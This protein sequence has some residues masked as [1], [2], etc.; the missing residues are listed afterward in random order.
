MKIDTQLP[1]SEKDIEKYFNETPWW[2]WAGGILAFFIGASLNEWVGIIAG[3]GVTV[4]LYIHAAGPLKD[5]QIDEFWHTIAKSRE[6]EA[7][8]VANY[9]KEDVIRDATY[10]FGYA[11][12]VAPGKTHRTKEGDD[13][14]VRHNHQKLIYMIYGRDQL[15]VFDETICLEN[16]WDGADRTE[17]FYWNDVSSVSFDEKWDALQMAVGPRIVVY[18]LTGEGADSHSAYS[19][20]AQ[21]VANAVRLVLR[22][23]K[24]AR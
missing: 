18:P 12:Q 14:R 8:R 6:D 1:Y 4:G 23:R 21:E 24:A 2:V 13:K 3:L 5:R 17:E 7:Y 16:Q 11:E 9:D 22:E 10:F 19:A 15:I 20:Q